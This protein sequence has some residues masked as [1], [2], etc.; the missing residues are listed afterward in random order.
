MILKADSLSYFVFDLDDT[1]YSE[2]DYLKSAY[3]E[4]CN[5]L[6]PENL[7]VVYNEMLSIHFSGGN[8]FNFLCGNFSSKN[9]TL[10]KLLYL[11]RNHF[12]TISLR[13][14]V[15]E[16]LLE[17]KSRKGKIGIITDGREITQTNK[18]NALGLNKLVDKLVI[19]EK[20]GESKPSS[21]LYESFMTHRNNSQFYYIADNVSKDF[22]SPKKLAWTCIG[23]LNPENIHKQNLNEY[24][25]EY[26]PH[27]FVNKFTEIG[28]I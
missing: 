5:M 13:E 17:I 7:E 19:S 27:V 15:M 4:I 9:L 12:P 1:L 3:Y 11:Y 24:S 16:L 14:G 26:L 21:A 8:A 20:F 10:E 22:I 2:I 28:I 6:V 18:I 23:I 25:N